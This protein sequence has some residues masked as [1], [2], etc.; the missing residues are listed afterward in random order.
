MEFYSI[1][2]GTY[3]YNMLGFD[4]EFILRAADLNVEKNNYVFK[5]LPYQ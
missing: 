1:N 4:R 5:I 2:K 3:M